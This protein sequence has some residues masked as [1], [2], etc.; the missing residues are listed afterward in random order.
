MDIKT[1][2]VSQMAMKFLSLFALGLACFSCAHRMQPARLVDVQGH[3]FREV[4]ADR[5]QVDLSL[6]VLDKDIEAASRRVA[7]DS[8]RLKKQIEALTLK[9]IELKTTHYSVQERRD[10]IKDR[11]VSLGFEARMSLRVSSSEISR[12]GELLQVAGREGVQEVG[13]LQSYISTARRESERS[14]CLKQA[15]L[16]ARTKADGM[17]GSLGASVG[18]VARVTEE[19]AVPSAIHARE[20]MMMDAVP[21]MKSMRGAPAPVVEGGKEELRYSVSVSFEIR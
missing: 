15:V 4:A 20:V 16:D 9:D 13:A 5:G 8:A 14:E 12:M 7:D 2:K 10:W 6:I 1:D 18:K 3:C 11:Q 21:T 17:L 19:G